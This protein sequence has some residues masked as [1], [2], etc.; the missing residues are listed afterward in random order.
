[1]AKTRFIVASHNNKKLEEIKAI[2]EDLDL[3]IVSL[4]DLAFEE[5]IVEDG[6]TFEEN[7]LI[8]VR[9]IR[10]LYPSA[11]IMAD[12]SGLSV[13]CLDGEPGIYSARYAGENSS[14][15]EKFNLLWSRM[16]ARNCQDYAASFYCAIAV[17]RPDGSE[18][19]VHGA[20]EGEII[21]EPRGDFGFGYDPIFYLPAY[22]KTTAE[23]DPMLKNQISHR[24]KA[25]KAMLDV[26]NMELL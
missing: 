5:E 1:M 26:L 7:A 10:K 2:L 20:L 9:E 19:L 25:L 17:I 11:Y 8:K 13:N 15:Q 3:N 18:F 24:A 12:D 4:R 22:K 23:L 6:Q 21:K 16:E 14:Y